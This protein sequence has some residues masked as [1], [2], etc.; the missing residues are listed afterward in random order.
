M[1]TFTTSPEK[2]HAK[3]P[4]T[5]RKNNIY[6]FLCV[7]EPKVRCELFVR[8]SFKKFCCWLAILFGGILLPIEPLP[9]LLSPIPLFRYLIQTVV[10]VNQTVVT[11]NQT[12]VTVNQMVVT[13]NQMV[14]TVNHLDYLNLKLFQYAHELF[15]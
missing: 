1:V 2:P 13:V 4:R 9:K 5:Q 10:T 7:R 8:N 6:Y 14:V 11:V 15:L 3:A 12:V